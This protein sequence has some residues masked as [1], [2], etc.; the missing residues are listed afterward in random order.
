MSI[1]AT[2]NAATGIAMNDSNGV[3]VVSTDQTPMPAAKAMMLL[4]AVKKG[5]V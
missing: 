2:S 5:E 4:M 3:V 1:I